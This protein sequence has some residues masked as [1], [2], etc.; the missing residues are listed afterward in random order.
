MIDLFE[1]WVATCRQRFKD[2]DGAVDFVRRESPS[3]A[4]V[5]TLESK[6]RV[7]S[8]TLWNIGACDIHMLSYE[9]GRPVLGQRYDVK[10]FDEIASILEDVCR[11][12][13][14]E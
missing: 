7:A 3:P 8:I 13:T 2:K 14:E 9:T 1:E 10:S 12:M 5:A 11:R 4:A 6:T